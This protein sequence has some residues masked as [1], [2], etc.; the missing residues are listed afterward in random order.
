MAGMPSVA[1][2]ACRFSPSLEHVA[3]SY[4]QIGLWPTPRGGFLVAD[5]HAIKVSAHHTVSPNSGVADWNWDRRITVPKVI[6]NS[7]LQFPKAVQDYTI[8]K[9]FGNNIIVTEFDEWKRYRK[10]AAPAFGEVRDCQ[11]TCHPVR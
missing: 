10:I 7:R 8:L 11:W 9:F 4:A 5:A 3:D 2:V 6:F 1:Y